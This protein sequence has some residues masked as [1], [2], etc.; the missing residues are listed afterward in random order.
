M[1]GSKLKSMVESLLGSKVGGVRV[2]PIRLKIVGIFVVFLLLS[3]FIS[4][5]INLAYNRS[6]QIRLTTEFLVR[7]LKD[8]YLFSSTQYKLFRQ[9][10]DKPEVFYAGIEEFANGQFKQEKSVALGI[11]GDGSILFAAGLGNDQSVFNDSRALN[12]F[13]EARSAGRMDGPIEFDWQGRKYFGIFRYSADWNVYMVRGEE[14]EEFYEP[15]LRI[16][17]NITVIIAAFSLVAVIAGAFLLGYILRYV[18][19]MTQSIMDMQKSQ[20]MRIIDMSGAPNDDISYLGVAMNNLSSTI[21]NLVEMF[22]KFVARDVALQ[23]YKE[24]EIRLEGSKRNLSIMFSDIKGFTFMTETLGNDIIKLLN[25]HYN[26]AI[27]VIHRHDGDIG[28]IIGDAILAVFG[29]MTTAS[30]NKSLQAVRSG[31]EILV[32]AEDLR[33]AMNKRKVEYEKSL[34]RLEGE[35]EQVYEAVLLEVGVGIDGGEVFYGNIGSEERMVNTVIGDNV[36]SSSRLEGLTRVYK[37]PMI[38][39][40]YIKQEVENAG[41]EFYFVELDT[42]QVKG[43]TIGKKIYW[44][45]KRQSLEPKLHV[46]LE[47]FRT[48]LDLYYSGNWPRVFSLLENST[49]PFAPVFRERTRGRTAPEGWRGIWAMTDK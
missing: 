45:I 37:V 39:S 33:V 13:T 25:L 6:E 1:A 42:V 23:A 41:D 30:Q 3:N 26:K 46:E 28:S 49:L 19:R 11:T 10:A 35:A 16:M 44:P 18:G 9:A 22:K 40:G 48:V 43:K 47:A 15:S 2:V 38:V 27:N 29:T 12:V 14:W 21:Q 4:N 5:F 8:L 31:Y 34:G 36:N 20:E 32:V 17:S 7:D 24:R